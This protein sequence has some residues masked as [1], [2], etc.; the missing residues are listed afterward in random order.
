M[1]LGRLPKDPESFVS[2]RDIADWAGVS[3]STVDRAV[4][5][6]ELAEPAAIGS[7]MSR[8]GWLSG[9]LADPSTIWARENSCGT[10]A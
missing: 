10:V 6:G 8:S 1:V 3:E 5:R 2:L 4:A 9:R 7:G